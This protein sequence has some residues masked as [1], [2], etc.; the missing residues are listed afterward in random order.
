M[1][2]EEIDDMT[3]L[4]EAHERL[5][6]EYR[7]VLEGYNLRGLRICQL[8]DELERYRPTAPMAPMRSSLSKGPKRATTPQAPS[9]LPDSS[10]VDKI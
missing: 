5:A 2:N 4:A 7:R 1:P 8:E 3:L 6:I 10:P 9:G